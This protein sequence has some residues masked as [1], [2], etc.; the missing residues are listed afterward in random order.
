MGVRFLDKKSENLSLTLSD[1]FPKKSLLPSWEEIKRRGDRN[2]AVHPHPDPPPSKGEG[3][4]LGNIKYV[5]LAFPGKV[6]I[7][8]SP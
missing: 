2:D 5:W 1:V 6:L 4:K 8:V 3:T 7:P